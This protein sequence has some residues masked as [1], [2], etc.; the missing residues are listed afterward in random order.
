MLIQVT[1]R[2]MEWNGKGRDLHVRYH[3]ARMYKPRVYRELAVSR[4]RSKQT[5]MTQKSSNGPGK[6]KITA[7]VRKDP[8]DHS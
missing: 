7:K 3:L 4:S 1:I 2:T 5:R 8:K 6:P